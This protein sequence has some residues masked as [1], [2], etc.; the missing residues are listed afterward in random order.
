VAA[1][2]LILTGASSTGKTT[3]ARELQR[4]APTPTVILVGDDFDLPRHA[5]VIAAL[6]AAPPEAASALQAAMT[7]AFY[8]SVARWSANGIGV[9]AETIVKDLEHPSIYRAAL[10]DLPYAVVRLTCDRSVRVERERGR[11]D[12]ACG[13]SDDTAGREVAPDDLALELDTSALRPADAAERLLA[14]I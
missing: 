14:F 10:R 8:E 4:L 7:R 1:R 2:V 11:R 5:R 3:I 12:R 13:V 6:R 9:I